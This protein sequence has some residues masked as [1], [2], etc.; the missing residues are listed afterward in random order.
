MQKQYGIL[1]LLWC[2]ST[3]A[4]CNRCLQLRAVKLFMIIS[5]LTQREKPAWFLVVYIRND[6]EIKR[7]FWRASCS[8]KSTFRHMHY[9]DDCH[10]AI[11]SI[12]K[13]EKCPFYPPNDEINFTLVWNPLQMDTNWREISHSAVWPGF[14]LGPVNCN[15][16]ALRLRELCRANYVHHPSMLCIPE[17]I[18]ATC[19]RV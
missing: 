18:T 15:V 16:N 13:P 8:L 9:V 14:E 1:K 4:L 3:T 6:F 19:R 17:A 12:T 7:R 11:N 10:F 2:F 5:A